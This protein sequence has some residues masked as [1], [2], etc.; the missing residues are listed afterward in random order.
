MSGAVY[1]FKYYGG[2]VQIVDW[3]LSRL[4]GATNLVDLCAGGGVVT[5]TACERRLF[6]G[7][8]YNDLNSE[9]VDFFKVLR[10]RPDELMQAVSLTPYARVEYLRAIDEPKHDDPVERARRFFVRACQAFRGFGQDYCSTWDIRRDV[11][12]MSSNFTSRDRRLQRLAPLLRR[13]AFDCRDSV[14]AVGVYDDPA[15]LFYADPPYLP[16][17]LRR[18]THYEHEMTPEAHRALLVALDEAEA[19]AAVSGYRSDLYD[20]FLGER[21]WT[22]HEREHRCMTATSMLYE[23]TGR[24][25]CLWVKRP[26]DDRQIDFFEE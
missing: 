5:F 11:R 14:E 26:D 2:K 15:T 10:E 18:K 23:D 8:M 9:V 13:I 22:L 21:G 1:A 7:F 16:E 24:T 3:I 4:P 25:E 6:E 20:S 12:I 19:N 17:T